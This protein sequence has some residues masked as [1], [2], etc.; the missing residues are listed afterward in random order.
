[1][2]SANMESWT[3]LQNW[4]KQNQSSNTAYHKIHC[5]LAG[6]LLSRER[7]IFMWGEHFPGVATPWDHPYVTSQTHPAPPKQRKHDKAGASNYE[8]LHFP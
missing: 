1:M 3:E 2:I 6:T 4:K 5:Y 7:G 8:A